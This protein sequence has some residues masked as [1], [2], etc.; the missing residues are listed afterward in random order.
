MA[1]AALTIQHF[2]SRAP[3]REPVIARLAAEALASAVA[4]ALPALPPQSVLLLRRLELR[5][6][7]L[8]VNRLPDAAIAPT[9]GRRGA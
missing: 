1:A 3:A 9:N 2:R 7:G 4:E 5:L 6:P 8:D